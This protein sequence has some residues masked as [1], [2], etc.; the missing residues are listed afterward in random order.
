MYARHITLE[1]KPNFHKEFPVILEKEILPILRRQKGFMEQLLL[2][3]PLKNEAVAISLW[4][5]KED[6]ERY[7]RDVYPHVVKMFNKFVEGT[8]IIKNFEV[9]YATYRKFETVAL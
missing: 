5:E 3:T 4:E 2:V 1:L 6:A 7:H 8:P 9:E